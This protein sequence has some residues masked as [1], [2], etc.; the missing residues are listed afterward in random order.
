[1]TENGA[2]LVVVF[3]L[4][5]LSSCSCSNNEY[6]LLYSIKSLISDPSDSLSSWNLSLSYC[7][8]KGISC[9]NSS[10]VTK[11][12]L[13]GK[14]LYGK[15]PDMISHF[16]FVETIDLSDNQFI[17]TIPMNLSFCF[18]L[19][20]LNLSNNNLT[21]HILQGSNSLLQVLDLSSN[22]LAGEIP[23]KIGNF[24]S[25]EYLDL[26]GN[27]LDGEIPI[28]ITNLTKLQSLTLASNQLIGKI[29]RELGQMK[30]LRWIY[31]GYNNLSGVIPKEIGELTLLNHLDLVK[32]NLTGEMPMSFGNLTDLKYLF[33][34]LNKLTG[35]VPSSIYELKQLISLDLSDNFL[36]GEIPEHI[37]Q[38]QSLEVLQ[39]FSNNFSGS[40][41]KAL[42]YLPRLQVLQLWSNNFS[43]KIPQN[44]G[45]G[46]NLSI[47]DLSSNSL[48]G[49]IPE[50]LCFSGFLSK[51]ILFSNS[52]K[53]EIPKS[54][55][56]CKTLRRIRLQNNQIYGVLTREL[57]ELPLVYFLDLSKNNLSGMINNR[58][59]NMP[60]LQMLNLADNHFF[61]S[62]PE[63]FGGVKLENLDL[64]GNRFYGK[65]PR[66]FGDY[67]ELTQ[68]KLS[69]NKIFGKIPKELSSCKNLVSLDLSHNE[70]SGDIPSSISE[71]PVLSNLDLSVNELSG[72][73][74]SELG[75]VESLVQ[76]NISHNHFSGR[77][78][79]K[80]AFATI[81]YSEVAE[82]SLCGDYSST[83]L[84]PCKDPKAPTW[85]IFLTS[86]VFVLMIIVVSGFITFSRNRK[87]L[88]PRTIANEEGVWEVQ[89]FN[90]M[91]AKSITIDDIFSSLREENVV[92]NGNQGALYKGNSSIGN[93][94]FVAKKLDDL[95]LVASLGFWADVAEFG[96]LNH[97]NI[98][99]VLAMIR[100]EKSGVLIVYEYIDGETLSAIL[101]ALDWKCRL[102]VAIGVAKALRH[103][104]CCRMQGFC[105]GCLSPETIIVD[106]QNEPHLRFTMMIGMVSLNTKGYISSAY[107][108]PE[109]METKDF[110]YKSDIYAFGLILIQLLTGKTPLDPKFG[111]N[112]SIL[113]WTHYCYSDC[114]LDTW[115][116]PTFKEVLLSYNNQNEIVETMNLALL[117]IE[118]DSKARPCANDVVKTLE[119]ITG[120][121]A[122][123]F[124]INCPNI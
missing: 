5:L 8:W 47:L 18:S 57:T 38:L 13:S 11:I 81:N 17:G 42:S 54:L 12:E 23:K 77:L 31:L 88:A 118:R 67:P 24:G 103:F 46:N 9:D 3:M 108:A 101:S 64:S 50:N 40:I 122:C 36:F 100:L 59:W 41:P 63:S 62:F 27:M 10:H 119:S 106:A 58:K 98:V 33:L 51:L 35:R 85:W 104:H 6:E 112:E 97:P 113:D 55:G 56:Q 91:F 94:Q 78:P 20:F 82:N 44:L 15:I 74:P 75:R 84:P 53:G 124:R 96:K 80:G 79:N 22:M 60:E 21:G 114:H 123:A 34:Y 107:L 43:G 116:D 105:I 68:L 70:L 95:S 99:K 65:I 32:N 52:L 28:T 117:C 45:K 2:K 48:T 89:F 110:S 72:E 69:K 49:K 86:S 30:S 66:S 26:G 14:N 39:I 73:V 7:Q 16:S 37:V 90:S 4:F 61:G 29:P 87:D 109:A 19:R 92:Y 120:T 25:L 102:K 76:V 71:L 83:S 93:Q 111:A 1:M 115:I 121:Q